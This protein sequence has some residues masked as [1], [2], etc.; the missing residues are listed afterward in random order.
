MQN[1]LLWMFGAAAA[2]TTRRAV[3]AAFR[4][5]PAHLT[6]RLQIV[7]KSMTES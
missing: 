7:I 4:A 2:R 1:E 6:A 5:G 3:G